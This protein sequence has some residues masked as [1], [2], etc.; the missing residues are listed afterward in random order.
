MKDKGKDKGKST[1][2]REKGKPLAPIGQGSMKYDL[3]KGK[4]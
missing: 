4:C 1:G 3:P 2:K